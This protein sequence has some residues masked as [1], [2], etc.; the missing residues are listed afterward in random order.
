MSQKISLARDLQRAAAKAPEN[1]AENWVLY[2]T[3]LIG[4]QI[5]QQLNFTDGYQAT[6]AALGGLTRVPFF[7][8]RNRN[9]GLAYNNQDTRDALP[10]A[11][12]IFTI[13]LQ[14]FAPSVAC[15]R[16][17]AGVPIGPQSAEIDLWAT[18]I[19]RHASITL[20]TN[21]DERLKINAQMTPAGVGTVG[22]GVAQG[23][24]QQLTS[25]YMNVHKT[26]I[27]GGVA[28]LTNK[29]GF[30]EPLEI[31]RRANVSVVVE[32]SEYARNL[33]QA[34]PGPMLNPF[35]DDAD[36]GSYYFAGSVAGM[37]VF[38]GGQRLVQQRGQYHA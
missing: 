2:D 37:R 17:A 32:F 3:V 12:R 6:F 26:N 35:R 4:A 13:G 14:F 30:L 36:D 23:D 10:Y 18:E 11:L 28:Q 5:G 16:N 31:P 7:N 9:H 15:Y 22:G 29:W 33:L 20:Q 1:V 19:A 24:A 25:T 27:S 34:M 21:Q 38:L 8:I